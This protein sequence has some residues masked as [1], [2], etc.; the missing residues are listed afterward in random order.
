ML[1]SNK[2]RYLRIGPSVLSGIPQGLLSLKEQGGAIW[3]A[4]E[5]GRDLH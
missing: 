1:S 2:T 3:G 4:E 5:L